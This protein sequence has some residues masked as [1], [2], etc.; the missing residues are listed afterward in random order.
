[1]EYQ[2]AF[3]AEHFVVSYNSEKPIQIH[4]HVVL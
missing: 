1:M 4:I 3:G 2:T